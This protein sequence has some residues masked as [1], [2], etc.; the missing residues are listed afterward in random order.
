[1][2]S[3]RVGHAYPVDYER[4]WER[5]VEALDEW[6]SATEIAFGRIEV[7]LS[8]G[9]R[10]RAVI[11]MTPDEWEDMAG[12]MWGDFTAAV[13]EIKRTASHLGPDEHFLVYEQYRLVPSAAPTLADDAQVTALAERLREHP[14]GFG[15]WSAAPPSPSFPEPPRE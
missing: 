9:L 14:E 11:V 5:L 8:D 2:S 1:M 3:P 15:R 6:T 13:N 10:R 4:L 12:V 7:A